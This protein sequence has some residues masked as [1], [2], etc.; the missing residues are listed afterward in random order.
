MLWLGTAEF[1]AVSYK[2]FQLLTLWG[3]GGL[4]A[5]PLRAGG[6]QVLQRTVVQKSM[7]IVLGLKL[8]H[9][10]L[11]QLRLLWF[12]AALTVALGAT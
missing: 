5:D 4:A 11:I 8:W 3:G 10:S 7:V 6:K 9:E 1:L 2:D 12:L